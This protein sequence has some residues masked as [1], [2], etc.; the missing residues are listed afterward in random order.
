MGKG[1]LGLNPLH[2]DKLLFSNVSL[3]GLLT[4]LYCATD[5]KT[6][7]CGKHHYFLYYLTL[8]IYPRMV[9]T[10]NEDM[11]PLKTSVRVGQAVDT[12]GQAGKPKKITGFQT[13]DTPVLIAQGERAEL[14][15]EE[16]I[17]ETSVMENFVM[18]RPNPDYVPEDDM[19]KKN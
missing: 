6:F 12:V 18:L 8:S 11:E 3:G 15:T 10:L 1:L 14:A 2:S 4:V 16:F 7:F 13:H 5:M 19:E 17:P 9:I